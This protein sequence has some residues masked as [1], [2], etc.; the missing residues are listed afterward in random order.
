MHESFIKDVGS[1]VEKSKRGS[2]GLRLR[3]VFAWGEAT[4]FLPDSGSPHFSVPLTIA[5]SH[6]PALGH[7]VRASAT[8]GR[9]R[10]ANGPTCLPCATSVLIFP[11]SPSFSLSF[12]TSSLSSFFILHRKL[13]SFS[14]IIGLSGSRSFHRNNF[15]SI[16]LQ[17]IETLHR[18]VK[19]MLHYKRNTC[20]KLD[21]IYC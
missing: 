20:L 12:F 1:L 17:N 9:P 14:S 15:L 8:L 3:E 5:R 2:L 4:M 11:V 21:R 13:F 16:T 19:K 7:G 6:R 10:V 18:K